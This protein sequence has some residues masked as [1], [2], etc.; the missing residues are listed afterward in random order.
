MAAAAA[1][2]VGS[3]AAVGQKKKAQPRP[4]AP[5]Q[6]ELLEKARRAA[7]AYDFET[8]A[9]TMDDYEKGLKDDMLDEERWLRH[10]AEVGPSMLDRVEDVV[11]FDSLT[12]D[13]TD[14]FKAYRLSPQSG[15]LHKAQSGNS[16]VYMTQD[17]LTEFF[18]TPAEDGSI[19]IAQSRVL[20]D[21][22]AESPRVYPNAEGI[23]ESAYPFLMPDGLTLYFAG[24]GDQSLGGYDIFITRRASVNDD[25]LQP[26][27]L[28]MPYNSP[29]DD[30]MMAIDET[31]GVGWWATDRNRLGDKLTIYLF[32]PSQ[33]RKN[34]AADDPDRV[35]R[36]MVKSIAA[37][38][39][40]GFVK[41]D[42][43]ALVHQSKP[44]NMEPEFEFALPSGRVVTSVTELST[45]RSRE[46][47]QEYLA[48][49]AAA[50]RSRQRLAELRQKYAGGDTSVA[51]TII[52]LEQ[53][54]PRQLEEIAAAANEIVRAESS[55]NR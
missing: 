49:V 1:L 51:D 34:L 50:E 45:P 29:Y 36:A 2:L 15:S 21:G 6:S 13:K 9:E 19:S 16:P 10:L 20:A 30:Y 4:A 14:F 23:D 46:L 38:Q 47:M 54:L 31:T 55:G 28:G 25:F 35:A 44:A 24:V 52:S 48:A 3:S 26:Q 17:G 42:V 8:V 53:S 37:T 27:N 32:K 33:L 40:E 39:P 12:V 5:T 7:A 22:T 43:E 18:A 11:I 41:P